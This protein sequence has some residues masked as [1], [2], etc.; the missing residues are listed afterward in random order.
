MLNWQRPRGR[1]VGDQVCATEGT[2]HKI[3]SASWPN[4]P[5]HFYRVGGLITFVRQETTS[6]LL[7]FQGG[8]WATGST[9]TSCTLVAFLFC[10]SHFF[11]LSLTHRHAN[12]TTP[13]FL[14]THTNMH[15]PSH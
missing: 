10:L 13:P 12:I 7:D 6:V 2:V 9:L 15:M 4:N 3:S 5:I 1:S 11:P 14:F 8:W